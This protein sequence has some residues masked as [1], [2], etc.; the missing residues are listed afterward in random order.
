[1]VISFI[2]LGLAGLA[3]VIA[4]LKEVKPDKDYDALKKEIEELK[5]SIPNWGYTKDG[6]VFYDKEGKQIV[7][8]GSK[9]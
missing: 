1:M 6:I 8:Q 5:K 9:I 3:L 4:Y 7:I 2:A